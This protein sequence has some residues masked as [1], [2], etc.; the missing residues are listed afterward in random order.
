MFLHKES[1]GFSGAAQSPPQTEKLW[2]PSCLPGHWVSGQRTVSWSWSSGP[3]RCRHHWWWDTT[4]VIGGKGEFQSSSQRPEQRL[5]LRPLSFRSSHGLL[6]ISALLCPLWRTTSECR[7][8]SFLSARCCL[9]ACLL[10]WVVCPQLASLVFNISHFILLSSG[11]A[12]TVADFSHQNQIYKEG[13]QTFKQILASEV[14]VINSS[15][16]ASS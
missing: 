11:P 15:I 3:A 4:G 13:K 1:S 5:T 7:P 9:P 8:A 10:H 14:I 2:P 12:F 16:A 6:S